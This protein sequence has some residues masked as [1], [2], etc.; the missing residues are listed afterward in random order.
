MSG[1]TGPNCA[2]CLFTCL[3]IQR[4]AVPITAC[5]L[6]SQ[7]ATKTVRVIHYKYQQ[8]D[9]QSGGQEI[10]VLVTRVTA[11]VDFVE[12]YSCSGEQVQTD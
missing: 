5:T 1:K 10:F 12:R 4:F 11:K 7:I 3:F 8:R 6:H 2:K 9:I